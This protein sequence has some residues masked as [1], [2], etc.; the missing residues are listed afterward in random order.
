MGRRKIEIQPITHERNRSVT[1][2]KVRR[3]FCPSQFS[4]HLPELPLAS[5]LPLPCPAIA[6]ATPQ[7]KNGLF[8]KAYELGVL[9]SVDVAVII[10]GAFSPQAPAQNSSSLPDL[11]LDPSLSCSLPAPTL[12]VVVVGQRN[13]PDTMSS[14]TNTVPPTFTTSFNVTCAYFDGE[15]DTRTPVDFSSNKTEEAADD[16]DDDGEEE[17]APRSKANGRKPK[18]ENVNTA[19]SRQAN[20]QNDMSSLN[21]EMDY[22]THNNARGSPHSVGSHGSPTGLPV[23]GERHSVSG[24]A[25]SNAVRGIPI[26]NN[27]RPRLAP[28]EHSPDHL[29]S[30]HSAP[31]GMGPGSAGGSY[32][33]RLDVDLG[34]P[35]SGHLTGGPLSSSLPHPHA[36]PHPSLAALYP[37]S[38]SSSGMSSHHH[39][40]Q[41]SPSFMGSPQTPFDFPRHQVPPTLRS[42]TFPQ[43][44]PTQYAPPP[45]AH[46]QH[47]QQ[48]SPPGMFSSPQHQHQHHRQSASGAGGPVSANNMFVQLLNSDPPESHSQGSSFPSFD[49]PI[50]TQ[51]PPPQ[52]P[53][54]HETAPS[55]S[56]PS[57]DLSVSNWLDFLSGSSNPTATTTTTSQQHQQQHHPSSPHLSSHQH[58]NRPASNSVSSTRSYAV[59]PPVSPSDV[60]SGGSPTMRRKRS[61]EEDGVV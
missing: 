2:L 43:H 12:L 15:K 41:N 40:Q 34:Y 10:F 61:R 20:S 25:S 4:W 56:Q 58:H 36:N 1:F 38:H 9:C 7:R 60:G 18:N 16:D 39:T 59:A 42:V 24:G 11:F 53:S 30:A 6:P 55:P 19:M 17:G 26:S 31:A 33:Y 48:E 47:Q 46:H 45:S 50:H 5:R 32:P 35:P 14:Y 37:Q 51:A 49:W 13:A 3:Y 52:H 27:K 22:H 54:R 29:H 21:L 8:K 57:A 44:S 23:S 28:I